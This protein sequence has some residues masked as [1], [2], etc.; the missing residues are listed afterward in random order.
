LQQFG[1]ESDNNGTV[2]VSKT[3]EPVK[4]ELHPTPV[5]IERGRAAMDDRRVHSALG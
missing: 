5:T 1:Q 4:W 3:Y 2:T